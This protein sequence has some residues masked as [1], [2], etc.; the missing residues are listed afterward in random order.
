ME[1]SPRFLIHLLIIFLPILYVNIPDC[2]A[3]ENVEKNQKPLLKRK[4]AKAQVSDYELR[5]RLTDFSYRF[6]ALVEAT[7][8]SIW[9]A[10][11]DPEI[12]EAVLLW[13]IYGISG[14]TK[15]LYKNDPIASFYDVWPYTK[16]MVNYF[17][18]GP[19]SIT[20]Q[21]YAPMAHRVS[22][23]LESELDTL[24]MDVSVN[25]NHQEAEQSVD[26][27]V[28]A[29]PF[30]DLYF[31]RK[32]T[33]PFFA[34]WLGEEKFGIG[35]SVVTITEQVGELT[36]RVNM[37]SDIIPKL[38]KWQIELSALELTK[39]IQPDSALNLLIE[40]TGSLRHL[41][42][43]IPEMTDENRKATFS[44]LDRQRIHTLNKLVEERIAIVDAIVEE[45]IAVLDAIT[46]ERI[47]L[48]KE[49][50][51]QTDLVFQHIDSLTYDLADRTFTK[52]DE[53]IN[54]IFWKV[55][56]LASISFVGLLIIV[57]VHKK[58]H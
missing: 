52:T 7:A 14:M 30:V 10:T 18:S 32:S 5:L 39:G 50:N 53:I 42:D 11:D 19:G 8:D 17:E 41:I 2:Q 58:V 56:I 40:N 51:D 23:Q 15:A 27:W 1:N 26:E 20:F 37:Y 24:L 22:L 44:E 46:N 34:K 33:L 49:L 12:K 38:M 29:N 16:Q 35:G 36:N 3:Q 31:T 43:T 28:E 4:R 25:T 9:R 6:T 48:M 54:N 55:L 47:E 45:R 21:D 57:I 13:K